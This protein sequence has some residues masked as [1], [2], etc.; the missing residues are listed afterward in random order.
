MPF[1]DNSLP[2]SNPI[3]CSVPAYLFNWLPVGFAVKNGGKEFRLAAAAAAAV[4]HHFTTRDLERKTLQWSEKRVAWLT[5]WDREILTDWL[6]LGLIANSRNNNNFRACVRQMTAAKRD[7]FSSALHC[8]LCQSQK[9]VPK[10]H[11][12][13]FLYLTG[14]SSLAELSWAHL[15]VWPCPVRLSS[16]WCVVGVKVQSSVEVFEVRRRRMGTPTHFM[17]FVLLH[18]RC[19]SVFSFCFML[20]HN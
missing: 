6:T 3:E 4:Y 15:S 2:S 5:D 8:K 7:L 17:D 19:Q 10:S 9:S 13:L 14:A 12:F 11:F 1:A 18:H 16:C 20:C